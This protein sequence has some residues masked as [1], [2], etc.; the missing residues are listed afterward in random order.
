M[1][2]QYSAPSA[3]DQEVFSA[4]IQLLEQAQEL[5]YRVTPASRPPAQC[6]INSIQTALEAIATTDQEEED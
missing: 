4:A 2:K 3:N 5:M 6:V 1:N